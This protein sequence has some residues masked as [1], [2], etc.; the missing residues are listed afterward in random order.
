MASL[1]RMTAGIA[2][3][4]N[5]PLAAVRASL[6]ELE[7]LA[8]EYKQSISDAEVTVDDHKDIAKDMHKS[9]GIA[10]KASERVVS[11]I[12]SIK[13]QTMD[14]SSQDYCIF[15]AVPVIQD[16][17]LLLNYNL[18]KNKCSV[19]LK[20]AHD[21]VEL[22]GSGGR[23][24]QIITNLLTNAIDAYRGKGGGPITIDLFY[25]TSGIDLII[26]DVISKIFDPMFSTKT[27][28]EG[29]GLGLTIVHDIITG[30]FGGSIEVDSKINE[31]PAFILHF[32]K[33]AKRV[34]NG[35]KI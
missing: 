11:F 18:R 34:K 8:E 6:V 35:Q 16:A 2:H 15:N 12:Q 4:M 9:L 28:A 27:L 20:T 19:N 23:L 33:P 26:K 17:I 29:T 22:Y 14:L 21:N 1:G 5:T 24:S 7:S 32:P 25:N 3:E 30:D 10:K 13:S 31:G